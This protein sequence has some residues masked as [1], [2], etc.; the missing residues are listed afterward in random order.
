Q[1]TFGGVCG[2]KKDGLA[3]HFGL[4]SAFSRIIRLTLF[5]NRDKICLHSGHQIVTKRDYQYMLLYIF[6]LTIHSFPQRQ[7][8]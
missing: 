7:H 2:A 5:F 8:K 1:T 6:I 4:E 3:L